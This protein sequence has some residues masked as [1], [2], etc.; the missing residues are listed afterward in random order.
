MNDRNKQHEMRRPPEDLDPQFEALL[1][2]A[3]GT[4]SVD[5]GVPA[6]LTDRIIDR[7]SPWLRAQR[8]GVIARIGPVVRAAMAAG[9]AIVISLAAMQLHQPD[10]TPQP[11]VKMPVDD[12]DS[13]IELLAMQ[14]EAFDELETWDT[15]IA[16]MQEDI[17]EYE[18]ELDAD[19]TSSTS[20]F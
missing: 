7:T 12:L 20:M 15:T 10:T 9:I 3:L 18:L 19:V 2:Q 11:I 17:L 5:G 6:D 4:E 14:I 8:T 13:Q 1:E 16:A